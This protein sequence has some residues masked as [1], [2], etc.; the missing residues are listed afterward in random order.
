MGVLLSEYGTS[1]RN[2]DV[3][4][5]IEGP[6][7]AAFDFELIVNILFYKKKGKFMFCLVLSLSVN[8]I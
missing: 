8:F 4:I 7:I 1:V 2:E 6:D 3:T 5:V